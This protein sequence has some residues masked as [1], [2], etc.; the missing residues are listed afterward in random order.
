MSVSFLLEENARLYRER[1]EL[2]GDNYKR[3]GDILLAFFPDGLPKAASV[4]DINR[5][6]ILFHI[7]YKISRYCANFNSGGHRDSLT[8]LSVY[9]MMLCELDNNFDDIPF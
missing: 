8:D 2:Y 1:Q 6:G 7:I 5:L 9:A 4:H 3:I